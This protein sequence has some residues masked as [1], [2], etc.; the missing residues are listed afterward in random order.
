MNQQLQITLPEDTVTLINQWIKNSDFPEQERD[1]LINEAI[2]WYVTHK[3]QNSLREQLQQG[4][5][6][7]AKRD[8]NLAQEWF[9]LEE[10]KW[11]ET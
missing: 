10:E 1:R 2:K 8:L 4:A 6:R 5:I 3:Q 11:Q 9:N 7:R